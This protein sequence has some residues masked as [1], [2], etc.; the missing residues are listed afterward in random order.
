MASEGARPRALS[1]EASRPERNPRAGMTWL[2]FAVLDERRGLGL[3]L[4]LCAPK[5]SP[6]PRPALAAGLTQ[7][8]SAGKC[9]AVK[10]RAE[11]RRC[12]CRPPGSSTR[13]KHS[14][15]ENAHFLFRPWVR[16]N[17]CRCEGSWLIAKG[18]VADEN[19]LRHISPG[20]QH[21][22]SLGHRI[23][24]ASAMTPFEAPLQSVTLHLQVLLA[25]S[26]DYT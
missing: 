16:R 23:G 19:E 15:C 24:T 9:P 1:A 3:G 7:P 25:P 10:P 11:D 6:T 5:P 13:R 20:V 21:T 4:P 18:Q 8:R 26:R 17:R 12:P 2:R 22:A 14:G